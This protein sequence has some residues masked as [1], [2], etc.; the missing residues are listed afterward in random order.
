MYFQAPRGSH[1]RQCLESCL[2]D[3]RRKDRAIPLRVNGLHKA[4]RDRADAVVALAAG[5]N[6]V[7]RAEPNSMGMLQLARAL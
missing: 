7:L 5:V 2:W 6:A 4:R 1:G 3:Q